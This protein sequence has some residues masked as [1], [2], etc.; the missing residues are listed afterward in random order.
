MLSMTGT[1]GALSHGRLARSSKHISLPTP[2]AT[3]LNAQY[4]SSQQPGVVR[5]L[6][7]KQQHCPEKPT[8]I[9]ESAQE[10]TSEESTCMLSSMFL[11]M[12]FSVVVPMHG[13]FSLVALF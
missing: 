10:R 13:V 9:V 12:V 8:C 7:S 5:Q 6:P 1:S 3:G 11:S 4:D 2:I